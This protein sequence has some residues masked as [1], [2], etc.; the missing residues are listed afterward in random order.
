MKKDDDVKT[1]ED[2]PKKTG[3]WQM[4]RHSCGNVAL[5]LMVIYAT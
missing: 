2:E 3:K 4:V 5:M 1:D